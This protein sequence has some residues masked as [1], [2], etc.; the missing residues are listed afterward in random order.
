MIIDSHQ[1]FWNYDPQRHAW[2][3]DSMSSIRKDF[4]P[5]DL[6]NVYEQNHIDGCVTV[7]VDQTETETM[8]LIEDANQY[9]FIKGIVGWVDLRSAEINERLEFFAQFP[10]VKGFRHIVQA[11]P[12]DFFV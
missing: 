11:E 3:D 1:H 7:Q 6:Q 10:M 8:A 9:S 4:T 5:S 12:V 2:I